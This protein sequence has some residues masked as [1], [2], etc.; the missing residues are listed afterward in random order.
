MAQAP[1][2]DRPLLLARA[3]RAGWWLETGILAALLATM[4]L[5]AAGQILLRNLYGTGLPWADEA[6][7]LLVLWTALFGAVAA[8]REDRHIR[9]DVLSRFLPPRLRAGVALLL[10]LFTSAV[11][12][13][14]AW[15]SLDFVLDS[16]RFA[17][18][19]LNG[20]PAWAFQAV[21]PL[22]FALIAWRYLVW[23][24]RRLLQLQQRAGVE[25]Q[26]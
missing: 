20:L 9:I 11:S 14:L 26:P 7:R 16:H 18:T 1:A 3:E 5:L 23:A 8:S 2:A 4:I 24:L 6:L 19:V 15:Y 13:V 21:L 17:D 10:D 25:V 12:G 22:C